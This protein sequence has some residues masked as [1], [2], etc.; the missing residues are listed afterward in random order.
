[1]GGGLTSHQIARKLKVSTQTIRNWT[2][3]YPIQVEV[4][5]ETSK[6][7]YTPEAVKQLAQIN[8]LKENVDEL[9]RKELTA[10]TPS[11]NKLREEKKQL[12]EEVRKWKRAQENLLMNNEILLGK[13]RE[14]EADLKKKNFV[15]SQLLQERDTL[16]LKMGELTEICEKIHQKA[17][18]YQERW[19]NEQKK[20]LLQIL[21]E[22]FPILF[23]RTLYVFRGQ[24]EKQS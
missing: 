12:F 1:M 9:I 17:T 10:A 22:R 24:E 21:W 13:K 15:V 6:R 2:D 20:S 16:K 8:Y 3:R 23:L 14:L 5:K 11:Y 18:D 7:I 19:G 4:E